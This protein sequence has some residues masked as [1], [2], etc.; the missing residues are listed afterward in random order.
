MTEFKPGDVALVDSWRG[1]GL[2]AFRCERV[3]GEPT[4][5]VHDGTDTRGL[6]DHEVGAARPVAVIDPESPADTERLYAALGGRIGMAT[7]AEALREFAAPTPPKPPEPLGLG[8][9]VEDA[10]EHL[11]TRCRNDSQPWCG[12]DGRFRPYADIAVKLVL[13]HGVEPLADRE[14]E[15]GTS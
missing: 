11:H 14:R 8:A 5:C 2:L 4:W 1:K 15:R 3:A 6:H 12:L 9:V 13:S 10:E 7:L